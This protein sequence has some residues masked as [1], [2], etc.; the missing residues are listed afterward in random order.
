V[1]RA[2]DKERKPKAAEIRQ[3]KAK[4]LTPLRDRTGVLEP[5]IEE[6][7]L[8]QKQTTEKLSDPAV[9]ADAKRRNDLL[10]GFE[11]RRATL[12]KLTEEWEQKTLELEQQEA[13]LNES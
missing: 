9:Y 3:T 7:E 1:S 4:L 12:A 5:K 11:E 13:E 8:Q 6:L 2:E 10:A